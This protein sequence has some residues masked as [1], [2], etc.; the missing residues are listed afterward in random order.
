[1]QGFGVFSCVEDLYGFRV[2]EGSPRLPS[3]NSPCR[4]TQINSM[5]VGAIKWCFGSL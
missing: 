5:S 4:E 2:E 1:M 3:S